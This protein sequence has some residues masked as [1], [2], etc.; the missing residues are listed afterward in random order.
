MTNPIAF[1]N[2]REEMREP[3]GDETMWGSLREAYDKAAARTK[4]RGCRQRVRV[5]SQNFTHSDW[6]RQRAAAF[7]LIQDVR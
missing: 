1:I 5:W 2:L 3:L 4:T 7:Y 6:T